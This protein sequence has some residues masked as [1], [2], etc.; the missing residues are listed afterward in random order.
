VSRTYNKE[1]K[2]R[3]AEQGMDLGV[4]VIIRDV[5]DTPDVVHTPDVLERPTKSTK[6]RRRTPAVP[7][8]PTP[9]PVP[10]P[11]ILGLDEVCAHG[12]TWSD[13][14]QLDHVRHHLKPG[15]YLDGKHCTKC[16]TPVA[17]VLAKKL[18]VFYCTHDFRA[19]TLGPAAALSPCHCLV[20]PRCHASAP[21]EVGTGRRRRRS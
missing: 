7:V 5:G 2:K 3:R 17:T 13:L 15:Q 9:S 11:R 18:L 21:D 12:S 16:R 10:Q 6:R 14:L 8:M 4:S 19:F 1:V 20:C